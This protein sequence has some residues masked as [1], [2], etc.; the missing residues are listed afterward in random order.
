[1]P[2]SIADLQRENER[3]TTQCQQLDAE[4]TELRQRYERGRQSEARDHAAEERAKLLST[5]A[6]VANLLLRSQDYTTVLPDVVR[7]LGEA[8]GSD[9]CAITQEVLGNTDH[10][11][12][13]RLLNEWHGEG[14]LSVLKGSPEFSP[15]VEIDIPASFHQ[16]LLRGESVNFVVAE[17]EELAWREFFEAHHNV[18][19]L[20][21]PIMLS[22]DCWGHIGFDNC[23][24]ASLFD[25][26]EIAILQ[27]AA[28]SIAAAI[29]RQQ[30]DEALRKSEKRYRTLFELSSEGIYRAE[31]EKPVPLSLSVDEQVAWQYQHFYVVEANTTYLEMYGLDSIESLQRLRLTDIHVEGSE[32]KLAF[33]RALVEN[34]WRIRNY[35]SEEI[36]STGNL[37]YFLNNIVPDIRDGYVYGNWGTQIDITELRQAQQS[38]LQAEQERAQELERFN[39]ELRQALEQLQARDCILEAT[40]EA[41]N[42]LLSTNNLDNAVDTALQIIGQ[43]LDTDR[44]NIIEIEPFN[45]SSN[46]SQVGWQIL[47][48]WTS[49]FTVS[50]CSHP[51]YQ[52]GD[53]T[54]IEEWLTLFSSGRSAS[55]SL[56]ELPEPFRSGQA[57]IGV[58]AYYTVPIFL[59]GHY[60]GNLGIDD[61]REA[62][63]RDPAELAVLKTVAACIG[64]AIERDR[65]QKAILQGQQDRVAELAK[66]NQAL[67]N[68]LD[69]LAANPDLDAFL[70]Y[71]LT[72]ISQQ[73]DGKVAT[74][75][76]FDLVQQTLNLHHWVERGSIYVQQDLHRFGPLAEPISVAGSTAWAFLLQ[77]KFPLVI[78]HENA[79]EYMFPGT[80]DWQ[81]DW[82]E[83]ENLR[84]GINILLSSGETPLGL[85]CMFSANRSEFTSE[86][87][88][89]A[90]SLSHQA[91][92]AIQ[93]TRLA[94]EAQQAAIL[95]ERNRLA[96][97]IHD[98]L[99]QSLGGI[100]LHLQAADSMYTTDLHDK[101]THFTQARQLARQALS[102]ARRSVQALRPQLLEQATLDQALNSLLEQLTRNSPLQTT[103]HLHGNPYRLPPDVEEHLLRISQEAITNSLRHAQATE[104]VVD[105]TYEPRQVQLQIQ[106]NGQGFDTTLPNFGYGLITMQERAQ[107]IAAHLDLSSQ[108]G[109]GTIVQITLPI[110]TAGAFYD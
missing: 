52:Q 21:V 22:E 11:S 16:P 2:P 64:S 23:Q 25:E 84:S 101:Q 35:E 29:E 41:A 18:A 83:Q 67:K 38:L 31:F 8:V 94:D 86:E 6:Q 17:L 47:N 24:D 88:E 82:A 53:H 57:E 71:V 58:K 44:V 59:E 9:R 13:V 81:F 43:S 14:I 80:A 19:M 87:L 70:G 54:G 36:D 108:L 51:I 40:A 96:R 110:A 97:D 34:D 68:S 28:E 95:G 72:E 93:L 104:L 45:Q 77:N 63:H 26:A 56:E 103:Y 79:Y 109:Q 73:F 85:I 102:E 76:R 39:A 75:Y 91:T 92:L 30:Q 12:R 106:D 33:M 99:A 1:M 4:L 50:Q 37:H 3:L 20:I 48:E 42:A 27:V 66:T 32:K 62:K 49:T 89:I 61:C 98:T 7:L 105:F 60:W 46:L 65:T 69:R 74:L 5:V 90:Q 107:Q 78:N 55:F 10:L 100:V 15:G